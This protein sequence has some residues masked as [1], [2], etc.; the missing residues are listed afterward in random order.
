MVLWTAMMPGNLTFEF[1]RNTRF[2]LK[3]HHEAPAVNAAGLRLYACMIYFSRN[4]LYCKVRSTRRK[5]MPLQGNVAR[6]N[7]KEKKTGLNDTRR[8]IADTVTERNVHP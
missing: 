4:Y 3:L 7:K 8:G 2:Y 6:Q 1:K 5:R